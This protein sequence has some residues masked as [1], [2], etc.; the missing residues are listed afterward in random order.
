MANAYAELVAAKRALVTTN[1]ILSELLALLTARVRASRPDV[2]AYLTAIRS[3]QNVRVVHIDPTLD[4]AAWD[5]LAHALDK[6]WS[7]VDA[8]SFVIMRLFGMTHALTA[9]HHFSQAG[10]VRF[11][12]E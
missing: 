10:F 12:S 3:D 11:P 7:L 4:A 9:D 1:Y 5:L 2:L 6:E 8:T